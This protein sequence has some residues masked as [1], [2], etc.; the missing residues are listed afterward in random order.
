[1]ALVLAVE[2]PRRQTIAMAAHIA[3]HR[4]DQELVQLFQE[5]VLLVTRVLAP[6]EITAPVHRVLLRKQ[7]ALRALLVQSVRMRTIYSA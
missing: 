5:W 3:A 7:P 2:I 4:W 6:K 1:M